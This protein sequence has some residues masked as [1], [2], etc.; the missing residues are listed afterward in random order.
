VGAALADLV[1]RS[2]VVVD[3]S[4]P[5]GRFRTL[6]TIRA[7]AAELLAGSGL[8][9]EVYERH[10]EWVLGLVEGIARDL[11][12]WA[13]AESSSV[14][15]VH[16]ADLRLAHQRFHSTD[17]AD[18]A[19]RLAADLHYE[20]YY[21]MHGELFAWI[22]ETAER[23]ANAGHPLAET[24]AASASVGA[25]Q[26]GDLPRA[27]EYAS[28]AAEVV[29]STTPGAGR[30]AAESMSDVIRFS[31]DHQGAREMYAKAVALAREEGNLP[32]VVTNL[33][34]GAMVAGYLG[35][36]DEARD[37]V[38]E[39]RQLVGQGPV[40]CRAWLEYAE[41][42]A[43]AEQEP[44]AAMALLR[45]AVELADE[46]G[47]A[48]IIGVTRLTFTNLQLRAGDA[49]DA[50]PDIVELM[51]HWR[52]RGARLQQWITLRSVVEL[53]QQLDAPRDA[54]AVLGAVL[55]SATATELTGPDAERLSRARETIL[56]ELPDGDV[57]L[58][59]WA[60]RDQDAIVDHA[61]DRLRSL[62]A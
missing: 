33:A 45:S 57:D 9:D 20:A 24:V 8:A 46:S 50:V 7:Y 62:S 47:A 60:G 32:R 26:A 30:G 18:R 19:L 48:F 3:R 36:L 22:T 28:L 27:A 11:D 41:G 34:D 29:D 52:Q 12:R 21:G 4:G 49:R 31:D 44:D 59:R 13:E 55:G 14:V 54:A 39:A 15:A 1:D 38:A 23:F 17:D 58:A 5:V 43:I 51:E 25:W 37:A 61:L 10:S 53:F 2:L 40:A 6:E 16:L 56:A 42:E 35:Y